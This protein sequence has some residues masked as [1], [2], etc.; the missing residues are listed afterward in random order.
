MAGPL[1]VASTLISS[2]KEMCR[3]NY[4]SHDSLILEGQDNPLQKF[5]NFLIHV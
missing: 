4:P 5:G 2:G 1:L 3:I